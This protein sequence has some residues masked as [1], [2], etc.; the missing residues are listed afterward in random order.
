M[1]SS[2]T[3]IAVAEVLMDIEASMR[4]LQLWQSQPPPARALASVQPFA[5]DT[6]TFTQ[7]LQFIFIPKLHQL[8][9]QGDNLPVN[10]A[11]A[12]M[13]EEYFRALSIPADSLIMQLRRMD[14]LLSR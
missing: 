9:G 6:L 13:A 10:S 5:I 14:Q 4:D 2:D 7:W 1:N 8:L 3:H 12:P 11:I